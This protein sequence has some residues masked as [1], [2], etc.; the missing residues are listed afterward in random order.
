MTPRP[1]LLR[2]W[3]PQLCKELSAARRPKANQVE[4]IPPTTVA[5]TFTL[6]QL[7]PAGQ[8]LHHGA[9]SVSMAQ[10]DS[11]L[12]EETQQ[13]LRPVRRLTRRSSSPALRRAVDVGLPSREAQVHRVVLLDRRRSWIVLL[14]YLRAHLHLALELC[15]LV[16][17]VSMRSWQ[18]QRLM[19]GSGLSGSDGTR[20]RRRWLHSRQSRARPWRG[21]NCSEREKERGRGRRRPAG[22]AEGEVCPLL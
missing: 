7:Y 6:L 14:A 22:A 13:D 19:S 17:L 2:H 4:L 1:R 11:S 9:A 12:R 15:V 21:L 16:M 18:K 20:R 8:A 3:Q 10:Y 5:I